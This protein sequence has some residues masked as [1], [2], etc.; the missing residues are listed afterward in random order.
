MAAFRAVWPPR[1]AKTASGFSLTIIRSMNSGVIGSIYVAS[2]N[3]GSV[4]MVA[5]LEL[6]RTTRIPSALNTRHAW[7]PE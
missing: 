1:V 6:T 7:V 2:A 5:G 4:I 3:S